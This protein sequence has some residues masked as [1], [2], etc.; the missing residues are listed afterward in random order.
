M[1]ILN[2]DAVTGMP[3]FRNQKILDYKTALN[4]LEKDY[5]SRDGLDVHTLL[6]S[7]ENGALTYNDFLILPGFIGNPRLAY[8]E[9][10]SNMVS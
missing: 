2:G 6:D 1:P 4:V 3:L 5:E 10:A 8:A 7:K 9:N